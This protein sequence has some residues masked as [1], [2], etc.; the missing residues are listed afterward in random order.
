MENKLTKQEL[1]ILSNLVHN[2]IKEI[3]N[4]VV[5]TYEETDEVEDLCNLF[6]KLTSMEIYTT[7]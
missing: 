5:S 1:E 4:K 2:R 6:D 7:K 3:N